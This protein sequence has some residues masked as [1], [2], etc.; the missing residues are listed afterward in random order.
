MTDL[1]AKETI[2]DLH[3][4]AVNDCMALVRRIDDL[5]TDYEEDPWEGTE[6]QINRLEDRLVVRDL[7]VKALAIALTKF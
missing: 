2:E 5:K 3:R 6:A 1:E 4:K 7:H